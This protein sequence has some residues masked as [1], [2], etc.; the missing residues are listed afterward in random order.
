LSSDSLQPFFDEGWISDVLRPVRGGKEADVL[1]CRGSSL[2]DHRLVAAKIYRPRRQRGF[3]DDAT[4]WE[5]AMRHFD[6]RVRVAAT[7]RSAFGREVR[8]SSWIDREHQ[9]LTRLHAAGAA[10][11]RGLARASGGLLL[12]WIGE[13]EEPAPQLRQV[14]LHSADAEAVLEALLEQVRLFLAHDVVHADLSEYNVLWAGR[15]IVIDFPQ[16]VDPRFNRSARDLLR[17]DVGNLVK[18]FARY[19]LYRDPDRL[20]GELW[21]GWLRGRL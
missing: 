20:A 13:G 2:L 12:E 19:G 3:A 8:F 6:R 15:P 10:V 17:R 18:H 21:D 4:Y 1:L 5:G 14:R 9:L 16:A 7:K 11:P